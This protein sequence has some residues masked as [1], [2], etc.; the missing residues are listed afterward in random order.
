MTTNTQH[1]PGPWVTEHGVPDVMTADRKILLAEVMVDPCGFEEA[2]ANARLIAA[3]PALLEALENVTDWLDWLSTEEDDTTK[4]HPT[5]HAKQIMAARAA[6]AK[7][8]GRE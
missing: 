8:K 5:N 7:A 3:A 2:Q 4:K 6:I 1:T